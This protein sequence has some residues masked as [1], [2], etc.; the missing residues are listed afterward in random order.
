MP[1][2]DYSYATFD[3]SQPIEATVHYNETASDTQ[4]IGTVLS[5]ALTNSANNSLQL[6]QWL[7][8]AEATVS[9]QRI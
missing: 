1:S 3:D 4:R 7:Y 8:M 6:Q 5:I 9:G 2:R